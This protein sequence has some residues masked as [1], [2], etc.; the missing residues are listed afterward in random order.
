MTEPESYR[1]YVGTVHFPRTTTDLT[2]T[3]QCPACFTPL[4]STVC[5]SCGLDLNHPAAAELATLSAG[6]AADLERRLDLIGR[7]RYETAQRAAQVAAPS[8][9]A[10]AAAPAA[11]TIPAPPAAP[12]FASP[13]SPVVPP[14]A[15]AAACSTPAAGRTGG[16]C[17]TSAPRR[18]GHPAH[19]RGLAAGC[20]C[21]RVPRLR[22]HQLR[23]RGAQPHHRRRHHRGVRVGIAAALAQAVRLG[24]GARGARRRARVPRCVGDPRE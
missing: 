17:P 12:A 5:S 22:V 14:V 18:A 20:R 10:A 9:A 2:S 16:R 11:A 19:R 23:H 3:T 7:M 1:P 21:D 8:A 24:G 13:V 4:R 15:P 6:V